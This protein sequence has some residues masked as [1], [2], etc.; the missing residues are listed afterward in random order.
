MLKHGKFL[1]DLPDDSEDIYFGNWITSW[2]PN[3]TDELKQLSLYEFAS[4]YIRID[5]TAARERKSE[6]E[7][8]VN[9]NNNAGY[10]LEVKATKS[11]PHEVI[12][13]GPDLN[14]VMQI[15]EFYYSHLLMHVP[16]TDESKLLD[17]HSCSKDCYDALKEQYP[18]LKYAVEQALEK[19]NV[20]QDLEKKVEEERK[21]ND[22]KAASSTDYG[23]V[24]EC[25]GSSAFENTCKSSSIQTEEELA[26]TVELMSSDQRQAY[27]RITANA[28]H[29]AKHRNY[30]CRC[31][32]LEPLNVFVHGGPGC[33]KSYL[34][35]ALMGFSFVESEIKKNPIHFILG[36]P[37]GTLH[38]HKI[39]GGG[40]DFWLISSKFFSN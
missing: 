5:R 6:R 30:N 21:K 27:D 36:A 7:R 1:K 17:G 9:L 32:D 20:K 35:R 15:D 33:G 2:Y 16:W 14:P 22:D 23:S 12:V 4:K 26:A 13:Y 10:M 3:R 38:D 40:G 8:I 39:G 19:R 18:A 24:N 28:L 29:V 37:T 11:Y 25:E 34:I 31:D